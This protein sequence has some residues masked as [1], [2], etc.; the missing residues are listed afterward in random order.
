MPDLL[1]T[2]ASW[3]ADQLKAHASKSVTYQRGAAAVTVPATIGRTQFEQTTDEGI[4]EKFES[5]DFLIQ[6]ADLVLSGSPTVPQRGDRIVE[7]L[8]TATLT[9]E[10]LPNLNLPAFRYSDA[11]RKLLRVHTKLVAQS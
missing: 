1:A 8:G 2:G 6:T 7:S 4:V 10:V 9:Y 11:Y 3:L 5:R